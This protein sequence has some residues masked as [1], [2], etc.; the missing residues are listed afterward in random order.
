MLVLG[1]CAAQRAELAERAYLVL[2]TSQKA[3]FA[4]YKAQLLKLLK[5]K[6]EGVVGNIFPK[7]FLLGQGACGWC[8]WMVHVK[9]LLP[10]AVKKIKNFDK[11]ALEEL[12]TL[13]SL[14]LG[15]PIYMAPEVCV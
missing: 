12:E 10:A 5:M 13:R 7:P 14:N 1:K 9:D 4:P 6:R 15:T 2:A 8:M 3:A 11:A